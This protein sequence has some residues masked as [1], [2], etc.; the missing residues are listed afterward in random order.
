MS[1][2]RF[3]LCETDE[4]GELYANE[5]TIDQV[6]DRLDADT[7]RYRSTMK[8]SEPS[9][10]PELWAKGLSDMIADGMALVHW[11]RRAEVGDWIRW[12]CGIAVRLGEVRS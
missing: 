4:G 7:E 3:L 2:P 8:R 1:Q 11:M 5:M 6:R 9:R 10:P 12:R